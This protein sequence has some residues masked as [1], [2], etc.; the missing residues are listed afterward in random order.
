MTKTGGGICKYSGYIPLD[1]SRY[2][3]YSEWDLELLTTS[4][5]LEGN[6][7]W[8]WRGDVEQYMGSTIINSF[9]MDD[10]GS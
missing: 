2:I 6:T 4:W 8:Y 9:D 5:N 1:V 10:N 3:N 7:L